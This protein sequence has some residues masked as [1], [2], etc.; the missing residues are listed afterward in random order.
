[1]TFTK[2]AHFYK[3]FPL[4]TLIFQLQP[5]TLTKENTIHIFKFY[6]K[7]LLTFTKTP[8]TF[9]KK[10]TPHIYKKQPLT[11]NNP[12]HLQKTTLTFT[13]NNHLLLQKQGFITSRTIA[14][15]PGKICAKHRLND[16]AALPKISENGR[17]YA[18]QKEAK[19]IREILL[20]FC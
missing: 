8:P 4:H 15:M 17:A 9:P 1:M 6:K 20:I 5:S 19:I 7:H 18:V 11:K 12:P 14:K 2:V 10:K 3:S 16:C 13:K